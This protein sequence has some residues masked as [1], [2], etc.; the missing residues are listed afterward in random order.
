[1][2]IGLTVLFLMH[3]LYTVVLW[4]KVKHFL[5]LTMQLQK[6]PW[7]LQVADYVLVQV[8]LLPLGT[9]QTLLKQ[10]ASLANVLDA[11]V[12]FLVLI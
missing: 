7:T 10:T 9:A 11:R 3:L 6:V 1:M 8:L 12:V 2:F 5:L 4:S